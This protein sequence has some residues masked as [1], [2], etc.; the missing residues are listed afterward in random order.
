[1]TA[2]LS[3]GCCAATCICNRRTYGSIWLVL[4]EVSALQFWKGH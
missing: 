2:I 1:M 4:D 3:P